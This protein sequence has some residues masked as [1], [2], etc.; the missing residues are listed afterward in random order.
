MPIANAAT[1]FSLIFTFAF[2]L[3]LA[4]QG[5]TQAEYVVDANGSIVRL[6]RKPMLHVLLAFQ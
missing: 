1:C 6:K 5:S 3:L 2:L 4:S